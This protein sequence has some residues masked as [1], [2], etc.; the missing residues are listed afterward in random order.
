VAA[1]GFTD[2]LVGDPDPLVGRRVGDHLLDQLAVALLDVGAA[3][4]LAAGLRE[5]VGHRIADHLELF[6]I[7]DPRT[8]ADPGSCDSP[9]DPGAREG[10][11]EQ[12]AEFALHPGDLAPQVGAGAPLLGLGDARLER[13]QN[14][15][16]AVVAGQALI[17]IGNGNS[18][19]EIE[20]FKLGPL[21]KHADHSR[22]WPP[23]EG[24]LG[25]HDAGGEP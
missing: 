17:A 19:I 14:L 20:L 11:A 4:Q 13:R 2:R 8:A 1:T 25:P 5:P 23:L 16:A 24:D 21:L 15:V 18:Q 10:G 12:S 9:L 22:P 3:V 7:Q 6:D